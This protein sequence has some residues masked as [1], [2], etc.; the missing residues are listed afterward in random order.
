MNYELQSMNYKLRIFTFI[1][2]F[3]F[4]LTM[5]G[6]GNGDLIVDISAPVP[7]V[8]ILDLNQKPE[9]IISEIGVIKP[10]Q[11]I[12]IISKS[13][14]T[15]DQLFAVIGQQVKAGQVLATVDFNSPDNT[16]R[17]N[18][19]NVSLQYN[20]AQSNADEI[21]AN[22]QSLVQQ[23]ELR[24]ASLES[25]I[26]R[27]NRN[28]G[29]LEDTNESTLKTLELQVE[30]AQIGANNAQI[31]YNAMLDKFKQSWKDFY[32]SA[33]VAVNS[34]L[35]SGITNYDTASSILNSKNETVL[36]RSDLPNVFGARDSIQKNA[37]VNIYNQVTSF[38]D[39]NEDLF[40]NGVSL[41]SDNIAQILQIGSELSS[42]VYDMSRAVQTLLVN[43]IPGNGITESA[44]S[45]YL[46]TITGAVNKS[47]ADIANL[48]QLSNT[49]QSLKL[50]ETTEL[51]VANNNLTVANNQLSD[52][53]NALNRFL[54]TN[55]SSKKD[56]ESQIIQ[57]E[58]DLLSAQENVY[59]SQRNLQIQSG[60]KNLEVNTLGNQL[61]LAQKSLSDNKITSSIN[62]V[63]SEL[64]VDEGDY[65]SPGTYIGK[66]IQYEQVKIVLN[67]SEEIA[68]NLFINQMIEFNL[69]G[70]EE[71]DYFG[72][73]SKISPSADNVTKKFLVE[74]IAFNKELLLKP[75]S[76][77][78]VSID[79]SE[80]VF[81]NNKIYIPLNSVIVGQN[82]QFVFVA[83]E[84]KAIQKDIV[85]GKVFDKW[86]TVESGLQPSDKVIVEGHRSLVDGEEIQYLN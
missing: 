2:V 48:N 73:I 18:L 20:N 58:N 67:V 16:A 78:N 69:S 53:K 30:N 4:V 84:G 77:V 26:S 59:T 54:I 28:L 46:G 32:S 51:S 7:T 55:E 71:S 19:D 13:A 38:I 52:A 86:V 42:L 43:S 57:M 70:G 36:S 45:A 11:E 29:E 41:N 21:Y 24:V 44:L 33:E 75:E 79:I 72:V 1:F 12:E 14:G 68:N 63:I 80:S 49:F 34:V 10:V 60:A 8:E 35:N 17:L 61:K 6:C 27:M 56:L 3:F 64:A 15:I 39:S 47:S 85:M 82:E 83:E 50:S 81:D 76:F 66:V 74:G 25:S 22:N 23:A 40:L 5:S 37:T 9:Y 62:G 65:V 31:S